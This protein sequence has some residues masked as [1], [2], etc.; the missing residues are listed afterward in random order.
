MRRFRTQLLLGSLVL[1]LV[2]VILVG[3]ITRGVAEEG[4]TL[5]VAEDARQR[6]QALSPCFAGYYASR[7]SWDGLAEAFQSP[8]GTFIVP[9]QPTDGGAAP[10]ALLLLIGNEGMIGCLPLMTRDSLGD[11]ESNL[12]ELPRFMFGP[13]MGRGRQQSLG[14]QNQGDSGPVEGCRCGWRWL[15]LQLTHAA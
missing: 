3:L 11:L 15:V 6:V 5:L 14:Q 10:S 7:S 13:G 9:T 12:L 8:M 4:L 1:V 2:P